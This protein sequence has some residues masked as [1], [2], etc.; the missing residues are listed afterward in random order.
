MPDNTLAY[1][2][3]EVQRGAKLTVS[4]SF[5]TAPNDQEQR[6]LSA[7]NESLRYL[8]NKYYLAFQ[9]TEYI[10]TTNSGTSN[11]NLQKAPYSLNYWR[12]SRMARS[13]VIRV[14]DDYPLDFIDYAMLDEYKPHRGQANRALLYSSTGYD[15]ILFPIPAGEQYRIRY[16]G[17]HIGTDTTGVTLKSRLTVSTDVPMLQDEWENA[18]ISMAVTKVRLADG[19]DEKYLE[20]KKTAE[21]WEKTL[22]DMTQPGEDAVPKMMIRPFDPEVNELTRFFPFG[23]RWE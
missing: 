8:N 17:L 5:P 16:Y 23:T 10:L 3:G 20:W 15:L 18:L 21:D 2:L 14:S 9:W 7:I 22:Y 6:C 4:S 19:V 11:Y 13:G 12:V 1:Y